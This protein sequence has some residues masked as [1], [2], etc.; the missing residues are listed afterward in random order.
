[1]SGQLAELRADDEIEDAGVELVADAPHLCEYVSGPPTMTWPSPMRSASSRHDVRAAV[2]RQ[3]RPNNSP[4]AAR[5]PRW[6][7]SDRRGCSG[8]V[9]AKACSSVSATWNIGR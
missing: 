4:I 7:C 6:P 8:A 2:A 5:L 9:S 1:E 3:H